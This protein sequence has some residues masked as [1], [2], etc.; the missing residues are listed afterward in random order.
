MQKGIVLFVF[1]FFQFMHANDQINQQKDFLKAVFSTVSS[2]VLSN[3]NDVDNVALVLRNMVDTFE[4]K[5]LCRLC[6]SLP[7]EFKKFIFNESSPWF[8]RKTD[9]SR[10]GITAKALLLLDCLKFFRNVNVT[11]ILFKDFLYY[12]NVCGICEKSCNC[13]DAMIWRSDR[14]F[15]CHRNCYNKI[16]HAAKHEIYSIE[17]FTES[18]GWNIGSDGYYLHEKI[19]CK[20]KKCC[21]GLTLLDYLKSEGVENFKCLFKN[22][23]EVYCHHFMKFKCC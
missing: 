21:Q 8:L 17:R 13:L 6:E 22:V 4:E 19:I 12:I 10:K 11:Q 9:N 16:K 15:F 2:Y 5:S 18:E 1:V 3:K 7:E 14:G 23:G 20:V